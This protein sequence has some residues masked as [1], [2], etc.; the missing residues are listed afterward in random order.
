MLLLLFTFVFDTGLMPLQGGI[1]TLGK[2]RP[3]VAVEPIVIADGGREQVDERHG[4]VYKDD[5]PDHGGNADQPAGPWRS[6]HP[7]GMLGPHSRGR[8]QEGRYEREEVG[9]GGG[10]KGGAVLRHEA[11]ELRLGDVGED[12]ADPGEVSHGAQGRHRPQHEQ[13]GADPPQPEAVQLVRGGLVP[14]G[15]GEA[16][17]ERDGQEDDDAALQHPELRQGVAAGIGDQGGRQEPV[18]PEEVGQR[19]PNVAAEVGTEGSRLM[20]RVGRP[21]CAA[22]RYRWIYI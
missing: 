10:R 12:D 15:L 8:P 6:R 18:A 4:A 7:E 9:V 1:G 2:S 22:Y 17:V 5:Q 3:H 13:S 19:P 20:I 21:F 11:R 14:Q 16:G